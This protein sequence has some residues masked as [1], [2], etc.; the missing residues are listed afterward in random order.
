MSWST[1]VPLSR[2]RVACLI[3]QMLSPIT[4]YQGDRC[5]LIQPSAINKMCKPV[6]LQQ[7]QK[8]EDMMAKGRELLH[9]IEGLEP[10]VKS[11]LIGEHDQRLVNHLLGIGKKSEDIGQPYTT[12]LAHVLRS[13]LSSPAAPA[14][15]EGR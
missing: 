10:A 7:C 5:N 8:A 9:S 4:K 11:S 15:G 1:V 13:L 3:S 6:N 12:N 2:V 14:E